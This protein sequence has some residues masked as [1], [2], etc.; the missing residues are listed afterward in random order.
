MVE[1]ELFEYQ[2]TLFIGVN[3]SIFLTDFLIFGIDNLAQLGDLFFEVACTE[4]S[5]PFLFLFDL[6]SAKSFF[7]CVQVLFFSLG[8]GEFALD[9]H[10]RRDKDYC[11]HRNTDRFDQNMSVD[12]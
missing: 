5:G 6:S 9:R 4:S 11:I 1:L 10:I 12:T 8:H 2:I 3:A 7:F